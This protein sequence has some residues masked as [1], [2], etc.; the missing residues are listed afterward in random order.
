MIPV[1]MTLI[2]LRQSGGPVVGC[3]VIVWDLTEQ[4]FSQQTLA[5]SE[6]LVR[7]SEA[8]AGT[9]RF[10][11]D[12]QDG[13]TQWSEGMHAIHGTSPDGFEVSLSAHLDLVHSD[14]RARV[15]GAIECALAG[16]ATAEMDYRIMRP[17]GR[18]SWMFLAVEP[19][20]DA[21]GR[22]VGLSG[23]CQDVTARTEAGNALQES[24]A[25]LTQTSMLAA[26]LREITAHANEAADVPDAMRKAL[27]SVCAYTGWPVGHALVLSSE[28][29]DTLISLGVWHLPEPSRFAC[30]QKATEQCSYTIGRGLP[31][32]TLKTG[33][34]VWIPELRSDASF[35]RMQ[36]ADACGLTA[37]F[38][39][40]ILVRADTVGVLEFFGSSVQEPD[41]AL[42]SVGSILGG[43]L[44]RVIEREA[45]EK[46]L[47]RQALYDGLT[48]LPNR[49]L[50][51]EHLHQSLLRG[52]RDHTRVDVLYLDVDDFRSSMTVAVTRP[53]TRFSPPSRLA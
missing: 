43:Q 14:E 23:I 16:E 25:R 4:V 6:D 3:S 44:G 45:A 26:L 49:A 29:P 41:E 53:A 12:A 27:G 39:L 22:P 38:A 48:G 19:R 13:S 15:A 5:A 7:R 34:P 37:A 50:L 17:D 28:V 9:G 20:H 2:P 24:V 47:K 21:A 52:K 31:G 10:V 30:F 36:S 42:L 1:S 46:R 33:E 18:V 8:L 32:R 51:M 40:P 35:A 11:V